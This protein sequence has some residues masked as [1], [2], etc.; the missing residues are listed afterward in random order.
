MQATRKQ[1]EKRKRNIS[2]NKKKN[3]RSQNGFCKLHIFLRESHTT[4]LA[5]CGTALFC[6]FPTAYFRIAQNMSFAK[7]ALQTSQNGYFAQ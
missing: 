6:T 3:Y 5:R 4:A 2:Q 1:K 7:S